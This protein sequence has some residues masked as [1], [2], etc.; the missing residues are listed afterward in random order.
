MKNIILAMTKDSRYHHI[1][2]DF[3]IIMV[4]ITKTYKHWAFYKI[5]IQT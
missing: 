5:S 1:A 2:V 3:N 4:V